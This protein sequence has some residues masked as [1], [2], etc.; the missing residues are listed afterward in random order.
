MG[1]YNIY[2]GCQIKIGNDLSLKDYA[3]GD[4][5]DIPD[6]IYITLDGIIIIK[7]GIFIGVNEKIFD[8][9]GGEIDQ[10]GVI[11]LIKSSNPVQIAMD[12]YKM[13]LLPNK[14]LPV[15]IAKPVCFGVNYESTDPGCEKCEI[16]HIC[17]KV[18]LDKLTEEVLARL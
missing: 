1:L 4:K 17:L 11:N 18:S 8:K 10:D 2:A 14:R 7:N 6:G 3:L 16:S 13:I 9:W 15:I 12:E 5:A